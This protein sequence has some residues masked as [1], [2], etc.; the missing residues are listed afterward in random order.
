MKEI[1]AIEELTYT[2]DTIND[3][4]KNMFLFACYTGL[5]ISDVIRLKSNYCKSS[6]SG[7]RL[8]FKTFKAKKMA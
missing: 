6:D 4:V 7:W 1:K 3:V 8:E 2:S 5:R